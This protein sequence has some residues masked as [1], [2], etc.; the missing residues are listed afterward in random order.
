MS[1]P[2]VTMP[3]QPATPM[4]ML[5]RALMSGAAPETL[6]KMLV[7]Q[8]RWEKNEARKAFDRAI[9]AAKSKL[10]VIKKN[11]TVSYGAGKTAYA[12]E[13]LAEIER[14]VV[15]ILSEHGLS[16]RWRTNVTDKS[17]IVTCILSHQ[18]G[19][20]EENS[21]PGPADTSGSKNA[22]QAIGSAVTYLQRYTLKAALGL[23]ASEDDDAVSVKTNGNGNGHLSDDQIEDLRSAI[24]DA[25]ADIGRFCRVYS[26]ER[27]EALPARRLK[28]A[29]DKLAAFKRQRE[30]AN[31]QV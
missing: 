22:L 10:P 28:E 8:E 20:S 18:E 17:I 14:T 24:V 13:D 30:A 21:L 7:L 29:M 25:G 16:Y 27:V 1:A 3:V 15:P 12:H 5:N 26:I 19:H 4:E 11:R 9:T 23:S 6:E 2:P 31:G